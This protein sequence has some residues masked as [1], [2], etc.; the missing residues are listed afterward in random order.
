MPLLKE[1][2][3]LARMHRDGTLSDAEYDAA[4]SAILQDV[5]EAQMHDPTVAA[6][7]DTAMLALCCL[8]P[9]MLVGALVF[10]LGI[11]AMLSLTLAVTLLAAIVI[12]QFH[13]RDP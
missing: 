4:K 2:E 13:R 1:I 11:P 7:I 5:P 9:P 8:A 3:T 12:A 6:V 10:A